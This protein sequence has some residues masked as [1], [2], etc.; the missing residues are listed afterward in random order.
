MIPKLFH[1]AAFAPRPKDGPEDR[2]NGAAPGSAGMRT[3]L[4]LLGSLLGF[5]AVHL[6]HL[7]GPYGLPWLMIALATLAS[8][9]GLRW[10][11][12]AAAMTLALDTLIEPTRNPFW[13][14]LLLLLSVLIADLV[15]RD[16]RR[17]YR[18]QKEASA[19]LALL[20]AA[21]EGLSNLSGRKDIL[22]ALPELLGKHGEGHV[23]VWQLEPGGL[24]LVAS[25]G[26]DSAGQ[27]WQ[28]HEKVIERCAKEGQPIHILDVTE[29]PGY[30]PAPGFQALSELALPLLERGQVVAVLNLERSQRFGKRELEGFEHFAKAAS[31]QLTQLSERRELQF[32]GQFSASLDSANTPQ[33]VAERALALLVEALEMSRGAVWIQQGARM[34]VLTASGKLEG[35]E[36]ELLRQGVPF[37]PGLIWEVYRTGRPLYTQDYSQDSHAIRKY[38]EG[39]GGSVMHPI[40][41]GTQPRP[42]IVLSLGQDRPRLWREAEKDMLAAACRTLGLALEGVLAAQQR[43][44]LIGLSREAAESQTEAV[45]QKILEAAVRLVPGAEAGSLLVRGESNFHFE[46]L[47]GFDESLKEQMFSEA[48]QFHWYAGTAGNWHGGEPRILSSAGANIQS[49]S[50]GTWDERLQEAG[51]VDEIKANLALPVVYRGQV[52]AIL[53]LDNLQDPNAFGEDSLG[54]ARFF[55]APIAALLHEV[56]YRALL[57]QAALTDAL[58][59]LPNRRAFDLRLGEELERAH[60]YGHSLSLLVMDLR[61]FKRVNDALGH[62]KGDAAL[63]RVAEALRGTKREGDALYRWGGDE[64]AAILPHTDLDGATRAAERYA[65]AIGEIGGEG[66]EIGVNIGAAAYPAEALGHDDLLRLADG[67][68]YQAKS[69]GV[70]VV[71]LQS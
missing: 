32:L 42:R 4:I 39:R 37:G 67:R 20:V 5:G 53:Y 14:A 11:L 16:L 63:V 59:H 69:Q 22:E 33:G 54:T 12:P 23:S 43:D 18:R 38:S 17:T 29:Q 55:A 31:V 9:Y 65:S 30:A 34:N 70:S 48:E 68:M 50:K 71:E 41:I 3:G 1:L 35:P 58:T 21:L 49:L 19:Q 47:L 66:F 6:F 2:P 51:R 7:G 46:A 52:L 28:M 64:F 61:G 8:A 26:S 13:S 56:R 25:A 24:R 10:G 62:A 60:R 36:T 57:E 15:G 40:L 44:I 27:D 45:Y